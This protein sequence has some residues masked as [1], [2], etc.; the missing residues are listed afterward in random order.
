M[1]RGRAAA[2]VHQP[3]D[4]APNTK[5]YRKSPSNECD[6]ASTEFGE[7]GDWFESES[8]SESEVGSAGD[9]WAGPDR[10]SRIVLVSSPSQEEATLLCREAREATTVAFDVEWQPDRRKGSNNP[11]A[12]LQLAFES[13]NVFVLQLASLTPLPRELQDLM[14]RSGCRRVG[15]GTRRDVAKLARAGIKVGAVEDLQVRC[16]DKFCCADALPG[17]GQ[18]AQSLLGFEL[19]KDR[20]VTCSNWASGALTPA[21]VEY[22][23]MDAWVTLRICWALLN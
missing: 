3:D 19:P 13:G 18:V 12:V 11:A 1:K 6:E 4:G 21:Q 10:P 17:L 16:Q 8:E 5:R 20:S 14:R 9:P 22:A 15:F 23:A 7:C 2:P